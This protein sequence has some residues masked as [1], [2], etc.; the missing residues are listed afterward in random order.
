MM[1]CASYHDSCRYSK[2]PY[3]FHC[4]TYPPKLSGNGE[5]PLAWPQPKKPISLSGNKTACDKKDKNWTGLTG[6]K[7]KK[8]VPPSSTFERRFPLLPV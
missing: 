8:N 3:P 7:S 6:Q 1:G 5:D 4:E 2:C